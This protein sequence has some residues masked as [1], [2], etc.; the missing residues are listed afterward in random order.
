MN[1]WILLLALIFTLYMTGVIV[2]MQLLEY[3]LFGLVGPKEFPQYHAF[4][5]RSLPILVFLPTL[6][7]LISAVLLL[8]IRPP[9]LPFWPALL[10]VVCDLGIIIS[11]A[12]SQAPL[13]GKLDRDGFSAEIITRLVR[14]NWIRTVLWIANALLLLG[15]TASVLTGGK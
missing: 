1:F 15:M 6:L 5:N 12:I 7:A 9:S 10:V 11:T 14:T 4:H 3:P 2:S 8:W 13:H